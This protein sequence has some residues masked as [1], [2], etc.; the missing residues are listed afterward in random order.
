MKKTG[1]QLGNRQFV[2]HSSVLERIIQWLHN[3]VKNHSVSK[4]TVTM[5]I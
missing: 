4:F 2:L 5:Q 3:L 1:A